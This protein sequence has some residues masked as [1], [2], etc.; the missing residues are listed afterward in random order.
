MINS[1][2]PSSSS[3]SSSSSSG[4]NEILGCEDIVRVFFTIDHIVK[5]YHWQTRIYARHKAS[6]EL[7]GKFLE[8][9]DTFVEVYIGRYTRPKFNGSLNIKI[10][11][12]N[13]KSMVTF[14]TDFVLYL[15]VELIKYL[16][17]SDTELL[18]IRDE[19]ISTLN[20]TLY[21]FTLE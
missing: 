21:L 6:D 11:E 20:Q 18:N 2:C 13:D 19:M 3:S 4:Y 10:M 15:E 12:Y 8:L 16:K 9:M 5:L 17:K 7:H 14:L 1:C